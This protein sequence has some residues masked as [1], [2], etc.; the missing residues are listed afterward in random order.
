[1]YQ[2]EKAN[3]A[4]D[5]YMP[6]S[7]ICSIYRF[8]ENYAMNSAM[9]LG[10]LKYLF[11]EPKY[12]TAD[13]EDQF[14]YIIKATDERGHSLMLE[15]YC[16]GSGPA[17]GGLQDHDS[18]NAAHELALYIRQAEAVDYDYEGYYMDGPCKVRHGIKD[19]KPYWE[20]T[21]ITEDELEELGREWI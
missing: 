3:V 10:Q 7:H 19:G 4:E 2:F 11:G 15:V 20:E 18:K 9:A 17:I 5:F 14:S 8:D 6:S 1:M 12:I 21:E 13:L 16:A